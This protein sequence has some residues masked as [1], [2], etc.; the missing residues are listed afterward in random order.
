MRGVLCEAESVDLSGAMLRRKKMTGKQKRVILGGILL[1]GA[2]VSVV[3]VVI[4]PR[5]DQTMSRRQ[6]QRGVE[7]LKR[8]IVVPLD[9]A[10]REKIA[11]LIEDLARDHDY[12]MQTEDNKSS[13]A[14]R[15]RSTSPT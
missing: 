11:G 12:S 6:A 8:D 9:Q 7:K 1:A 4:L 2:I 5:D 15:A 13:V 14:T 10:T 3:W